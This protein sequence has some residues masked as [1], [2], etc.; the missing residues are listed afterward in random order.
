MRT[1]AF[2]CAVMAASLTSFVHAEAQQGFKLS[3]GVYVDEGD[4]MLGV[5]YEI[6]IDSK[7]AL[8]PGM[9]YVFVDNGD[10]MTFNLDSRFE[11]NTPS[12]NPMWAGIGMG[13]IRRK[14]G[15]FDDTDFG[16]N[17]QWGMDFDRGQNWMPYLNSKAVLSDESYFVVGFG[18]RFGTGSS[19]GTAVSAD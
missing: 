6:P 3:T 17:L 7:F 13:A 12:E 10:L 14:V 4:P 1:H 18:I 11:L 8:I 19:S 15:N 5:A 2:V 16:V 9:E